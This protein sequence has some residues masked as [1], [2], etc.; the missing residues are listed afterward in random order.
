[1]NNSI[2][3]ELV[4]EIEKVQLSNDLATEFS[5]KNRDGIYEISDDYVK[6]SAMKDLGLS[7][8]EFDLQ[9]AEV[10]TRKVYPKS[11]Y[12]NR[13]FHHTFTLLWD[14]VDSIT[15]NHYKKKYKS[16]PVEVASAYTGFINAQIISG[17]NKSEF[18]IIFDETTIVLS[19]LLSRIYVQTIPFIKQ[20]NG[21]YYMSLDDSDIINRINTPDNKFI[22]GLFDLIMSLITAGLPCAAEQH[23]RPSFK[24][25]EG[26]AIWIKNSF[27]L[28]LMAHEYG[29]MHLNHFEDNRKKD[30]YETNLF[31]QMCEF[32]ADRFAMEIVVRDSLEKQLSPFFAIVGSLLFFEYQLLI[33]RCLYFFLFGK[34]IREEQ[35]YWIGFRDLEIGMSTHPHAL[36]RKDNLLQFL[37]N[38]DLHE[39]RYIDVDDIE[40]FF[41][42]VSNIFWDKSFDD[43]KDYYRKIK[44]HPI[45]DRISNDIIAKKEYGS[46]HS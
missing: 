28:F 41:N 39:T 12:Q 8:E 16:F 44:I 37:K 40:R 3:L 36:I 22:I 2:S 25:A 24:E 46:K 10:L 38:S 18:A 1:M 19:Q 26:N 32:E 42:N 43:F 4:R 15:R 31:S 33:E 27:D 5:I 6:Q 45:W 34:D 20:N 9:F 7:E 17:K 35:D 30:L 11:K 23:Y 14:N 21:S 13:S 29:H